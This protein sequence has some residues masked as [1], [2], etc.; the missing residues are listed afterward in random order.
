[1]RTMTGFGGH[2][3]S[4][5]VEGALPNGRNSPAISFSSS[6]LMLP[7]VSIATRR[8]FGRATSGR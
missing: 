6:V 3:E 2:F 8:R 7:D 4:E 1:M 5:A